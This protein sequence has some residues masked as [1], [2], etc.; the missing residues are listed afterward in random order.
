MRCILCG[1]KEWLSE[2][3]FPFSFFVFSVERPD[4][5]ITDEPFQYPSGFY[6]IAKKESDYCSLP[7]TF[8]ACD[9][10][11]TYRVANKYEASSRI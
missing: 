8:P 5:N 11:R 6:K 7:C 9:Y 2:C 10:T 3:R 1:F 4:F